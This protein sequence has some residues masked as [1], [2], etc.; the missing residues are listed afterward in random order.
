[1][2]VCGDLAASGQ[3]IVLVEQNLA[4]TL[5]LAERIYIINNGHIVHEDRPRKSWKIAKSCNGIS[6]F[7]RV[8]LRRRPAIGAAAHADDLR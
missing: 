1:M 2:R 6:G 7:R 3:T 8:Q 5:E 4:A